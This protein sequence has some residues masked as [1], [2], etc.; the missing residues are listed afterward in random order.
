MDFLSLILKLFCCFAVDMVNVFKMYYLN[1][2]VLLQIY[3]WWCCTIIF[4]F[5]LVYCNYVEQYHYMTCYVQLNFQP[6]I[7]CC[8]SVITIHTINSYSKSFKVFKWSFTDFLFFK[9]KINLIPF[10]C[11]INNQSRFVWWLHNVPL[12]QNK[13]R[14]VYE[15]DQQT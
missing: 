13:Y 15:H 1:S 6:Q 8:H 4:S 12:F 11:S 7:K 5:C 10:F 9:F 14:I 3:S 2:V